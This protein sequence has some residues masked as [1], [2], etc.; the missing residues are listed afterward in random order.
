MGPVAQLTGFAKSSPGDAQ[1]VGKSGNVEL[2]RGRTCSRVSQ[3]HHGAG[4]TVGGRT[5]RGQTYRGVEMTTSSVYYRGTG[6]TTENDP[7]CATKLLERPSHGKNFKRFHG[8]VRRQYDHFDHS[9][10]D[11]LGG[12]H[13]LPRSLWP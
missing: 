11:G 5:G 1:S 7:W 10:G 2:D 4:S 13:L 3:P 12:D 6:M 9:L 8:R